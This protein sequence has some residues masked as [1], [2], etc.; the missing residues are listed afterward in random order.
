MHC[1]SK[2][3]G[4][5]FGVAA[6]ESEDFLASNCVGNLDKTLALVS[7]PEVVREKIISIYMKAPNEP[8]RSSNSVAY[9]YGWNF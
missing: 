5:D 4:N 1:F 3:R 7:E 8:P 6:E 2:V 9:A